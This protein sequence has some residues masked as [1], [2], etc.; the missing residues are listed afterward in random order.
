MSRPYEGEPENYGLYMI[1]PEEITHRVLRAHKAG[2]QVGIHA[3][4]DAAISSVLDAYEEAQRQ[5]PRSD[6]RFRIEHCSI[7]D[8]TI[9][10]RISKLNAIPIPGTTFLHDMRPVYL[11]N[12]GEQRP[13]YAYAMKTFMERGIIAAA[14]SDAPISSQNPMIGIQTMVT[15]KDRLGDEIFPQER[16]SLEDAIAAYT[17]NGAY[18]SFDESRKGMLRPG[19][20]ADV[21]IMETDLHEVAP[22]DLGNVRCDMT[23]ADG[24]VVNDRASS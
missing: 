8:E 11:Q 16:I 23:I 24:T 2:F 15:R 3:I 10:D 17:R 20:L 9:I 6:P 12:L 21:A 18:A 19:M 5:M 13:R 7:I 1:S 22:D 14:S 4:G